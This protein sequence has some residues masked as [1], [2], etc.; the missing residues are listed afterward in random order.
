MTGLLLQ[1]TEMEQRASGTMNDRHQVCLAGY[2]FQAKGGLTAKKGTWRAALANGLLMPLPGELAPET[3][4]L[5]VGLSTGIAE[6]LTGSGGR[7]AANIRTPCPAGARGAAAT[8][9]LLTLLLN[10]CAE[11]SGGGGASRWPLSDERSR[12][13]GGLPGC[14]S[15]ALLI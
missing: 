12:G 4:T 2:V 7:S 13:E 3:T 11:L 8:P 1:Q 5:A 14:Q 15:R 10:L 9:A 6:V